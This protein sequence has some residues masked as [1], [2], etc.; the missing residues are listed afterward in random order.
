[1]KDEVLVAFGFKASDKQVG[2]GHY[3]RFAIQPYKFCYE[4]KLNNLQSEIVSYITRYPYKWEGNLEKQIEDVKKAIHTA[5]LLLEEL[6]QQHK[7]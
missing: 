4:N 3:K 2:G 6:Q 5:E 1:M 7:G